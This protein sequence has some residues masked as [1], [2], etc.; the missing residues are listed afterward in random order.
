M[1]QVR[2]RLKSVYYDWE[3]YEIVFNCLNIF[4]E[5]LIR[6]DIYN[7]YIRGEE[8]LGV[9]M[10]E[11]SNN[12]RLIVNCG[13]NPPIFGAI[14]CSIESDKNGNSYVVVETPDLNLKI[15]NPFDGYEF[16]MP[17]TESSRDIELF[18]DL[19]LQSGFKQA[20]W[21][22]ELARYIQADEDTVFASAHAILGLTL[23]EMEW[24]WEEK[25]MKHANKEETNYSIES[26][27]VTVHFNV[28]D[29]ITTIKWKDGTI[30]QAKCGQND[31]F[32]PEKGLET[33]FMNHFFPTKVDANN[34]RRKWIEKKYKPKDVDPNTRLE[35]LIK[36]FNKRYAATSEKRAEEKDG[37]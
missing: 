25:E 34:F 12:L 1:G 3:T 15:S 18:D 30:S 9:S 13:D 4:S 31:D 17:N 19:D 8:D 10:I 36:G 11:D 5:H 33:A 22:P 24:P 28:E 7:K 2:T 29:G 27:I 37:Q 21:S 26:Q 23:T 35:E 14:L 6:N 16:K 32:D 20:M